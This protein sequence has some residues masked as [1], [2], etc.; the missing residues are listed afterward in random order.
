MPCPVCGSWRTVIRL[1]DRDG[2]GEC[3]KCWAT[4]SQRGSEAS[5][6]DAGQRQ[7][8]GTARTER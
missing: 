5:R 6:V 4:W 3:L 2:V 1:S 8:L 7:P